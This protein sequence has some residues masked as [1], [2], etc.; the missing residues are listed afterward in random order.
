MKRTSQKQLEANRKNATKSTGPKSA[1][2][3]AMVRQNALKHGILAKEMIATENGNAEGF[4]SLLAELV[5]E[6]QPIGPTEKLL[7][8]RIASCWWRLTRVVRAENGGLAER[9]AA[10]HEWLGTIGV[11]AF[12]K[13][14]VEWMLMRAERPLTRKSTASLREKVAANQETLRNL[15]RTPSGILT[16]RNAIRDIKEE[17]M[18]DDDFSYERLTD[19]LNCLGFHWTANLPFA[20]KSVSPDKYQQFI[21]LLDKEIVELE[22]SAKDLLSERW[23]ELSSKVLSASLPSDDAANRILRYEAH[24][25][26]QLYRAQDQLERLQRR[27][28]GDNVPPPL[29]IEI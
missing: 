16:L 10:I 23:A 9:L 3:K 24:V 17:V 20:G 12:N 14:F 2:G 21:S 22:Q 29:K 4:Q 8:E 7:V 26:R 15:R 11:D 28:R 6:Y 25:D 18:R 5:D 13:D 19:M 1:R 27:R